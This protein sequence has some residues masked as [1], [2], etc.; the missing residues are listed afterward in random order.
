VPN[1]NRIGGG[2]NGSP[3][4]GPRGHS[5]ERRRRFDS[6]FEFERIQINFNSFQIFDWSKKNL[7]ELQKI[8]IKYSSEGFEEGNNFLHRNLFRFE[9]RFELKFGEVNVN[10]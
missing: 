9:M 2:E 7:H 3:T 5:A 8:E 1:R 10:F 4:C 6:K